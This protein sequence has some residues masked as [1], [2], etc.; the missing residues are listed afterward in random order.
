MDRRKSSRQ[1]L[2]SAFQT[3]GDELLPKLIAGELCMTVDEKFI[4]RA[5]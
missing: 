5:V 4:G 2:G 1:R 3:D